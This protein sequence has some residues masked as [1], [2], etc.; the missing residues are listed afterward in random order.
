MEE[1]FM[2]NRPSIPFKNGEAEAFWNLEQAKTVID[3]V[4]SF[5]GRSLAG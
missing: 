3:G 5:L 2:I 1:L 4:F